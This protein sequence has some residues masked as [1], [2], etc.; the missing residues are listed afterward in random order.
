[1]SNQ[2]E[3]YWVHVATF[4]ETFGRMKE[5]RWCDLVCVCV[6]VFVFVCV[7]VCSNL[8]GLIIVLTA[9]KIIRIWKWKQNV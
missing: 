8:L 4:L 2:I 3:K 5:N 1:M 9:V 6:C 7:C